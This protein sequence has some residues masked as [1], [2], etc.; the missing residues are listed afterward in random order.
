VR[1]GDEHVVDG[2]TITVLAPD[3][4]WTAT[5]DDPNTSSVVVRATYGDVRFLLTG[6][7]ESEEESWL[8]ARYP[9]DLRA[10]VLK[11]AHHGS[12]TSSAEAFLDAVRPRVALIS[13]GRGNR[14]GHPDE[15]VLRRFGARSV[16]VLRTDDD[17]TITVQS[18]GRSIWVRARGSFWKVRD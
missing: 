7:A 17:G 16:E 11:V 8:L 9:D 13:V 1:P 6:D 10:D 2:V 3:S 12:R 4:T 14:Y 18:D 15:G 5:R